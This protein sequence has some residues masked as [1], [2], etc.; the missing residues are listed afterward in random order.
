MNVTA[1][2]ILLIV[3]AIASFIVQKVMESRMKKFSQIPTPNGMTGAQIA[4]KMLYDNGIT[5]VTVRETNGW[6]TDHYDPRNKTVNL[7]SDVF[8]GQSIA[9]AAVAAHECGHAVQHAVAYA[10]LTMRSAL[11]PA[12]QF[13]SSI[14]GIVLLIGILTLTRTPIILLLGII[15]L[16]IATL[17]SFVTLPVE[18]NAS[19][20][21][22]NWLE[23]S[24]MTN[25]KTT[26][27]AAS[28]L[29]AAAYTYVV[30]ALSSL[31]SLIYYVSIFLSRRD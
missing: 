9:A 26:E 13:A 19:V 29:R 4:R 21:A 2:W 18:I 8:H 16:A 25:S 31:A 12:V 3:V 23:N 30:A 10:P 11:V 15:L 14:N 24:G 20:R 7:S 27:M 5:D 28:A 22:V 1:S 6:L 17:F